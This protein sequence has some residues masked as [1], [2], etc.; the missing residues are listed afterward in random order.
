MFDK[1]VEDARAEVAA[2]FVKMRTGEL[3]ELIDLGND[4]VFEYNKQLAKRKRDKVYRWWGAYLWY[5]FFGSEQESLLKQ[6]ISPRYYNARVDI[7]RLR[8]LSTITDPDKTITLPSR[9]AKYLT[10]GYKNAVEKWSNE[11]QERVS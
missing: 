9:L 3:L 4:A 5:L 7:S 10:T 2:R 1:V 6:L 11:Q 8:A